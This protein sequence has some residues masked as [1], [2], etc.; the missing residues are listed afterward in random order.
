MLSS[1][2][3]EDHYGHVLAMTDRENAEDHHFEPV[4]ARAGLIKAKRNRRKIR[5]LR[6]QR[7]SRLMKAASNF[8]LDS[9]RTDKTGKTEKSSDVDADV[10]DQ[11]IEPFGDQM[12]IPISD[13]SSPIAGYSPPAI[14]THQTSI[15]EIGDIPISSSAAPVTYRPGMEEDNAAI[16]LSEFQKEDSPIVLQT[17]KETDV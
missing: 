13:L 8:S 14:F 12:A 16:V 2:P 11:D 5:R 7:F 1:Q 15:T 9:S 4:S 10:S 6:R 17:S 3:H